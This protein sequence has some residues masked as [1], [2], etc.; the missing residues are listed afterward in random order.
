MVVHDEGSTMTACSCIIIMDHHLVSRRTISTR[1][2]IATTCFP[3]SSLMLPLNC[4]VNSV[5]TKKHWW[6]RIIGTLGVT[7]SLIT[8]SCTLWNLDYGH[9]LLCLTSMTQSSAT[10]SKIF[11]MYSSYSSSTHHHQKCSFDWC[12]A[13]G[14]LSF[15]G[16]TVKQGCCVVGENVV[17]FSTLPLHIPRSSSVMSWR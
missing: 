6:S 11:L 5:L 1:S 7:S 4:P 12:R 9:T 3:G 13:L 17:S 8:I 14:K 10:P 2:Q 15:D 16:N